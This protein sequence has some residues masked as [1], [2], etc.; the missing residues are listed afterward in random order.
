MASERELDSLN[1]ELVC[2]C[3]CVCL[4]VFVCVSVCVCVCVFVSS[5]TQCVHFEYVYLYVEASF[6]APTLKQFQGQK[7]VSCLCLL[8]G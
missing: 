1:P 3:V 4:C 7:Y 6:Y 8:P 2:L 5:W